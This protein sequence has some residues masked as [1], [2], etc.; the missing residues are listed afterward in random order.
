MNPV[1]VELNAETVAQNMATISDD[2]HI[3]LTGDG[4]GAG[5]GMGVLTDFYN[6]T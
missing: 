5:T 3:I 1:S 2:G 6:I 4:I